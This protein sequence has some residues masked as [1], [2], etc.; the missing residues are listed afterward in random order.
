MKFFYLSSVSN[1]DGF[2]QVHERDCKNIP[3]PLERDY[4]GPFNNGEEALR[5][6]KRMNPEAITCSDCCVKNGIPSKMERKEKK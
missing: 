6:A 4:L 5:K 3:D 2:Y 1:T